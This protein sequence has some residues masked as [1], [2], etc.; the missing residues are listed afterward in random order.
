MVLAPLASSSSSAADMHSGAVVSPGP[1]VDAAA[2]VVQ[3][4]LP[5]L[6]FPHHDKSFSRE[7]TIKRAAPEQSVNCDPPYTVDA[8]GF[9]TVKP[10]CR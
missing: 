4:K 10:E 7:D 9:R 8:S 5:T 1:S 6:A 2:S 3:R